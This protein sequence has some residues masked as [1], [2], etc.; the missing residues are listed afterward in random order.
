MRIAGEFNEN[1]FYNKII[2]SGKPGKE[3]LNLNS[4]IKRELPRFSCTIISELGCILMFRNSVS[5]FSS[6][7]LVNRKI[8]GKI[9]W[10]SVI[11]VLQASTVILKFGCLSLLERLYEYGFVIKGLAV[12][13]KFLEGDK[14]WMT[15][16]KNY[17][18]V[19]E[20]NTW[21][22]EFELSMK[23]HSGRKLSYWK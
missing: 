16:Y 6:L 22:S 4:N 20:Q 5:K 13:W 14:S 18:N 19:I 23:T 9:C 21:Y 11:V 17:K 12:F 2:F 10:D 15:R 1:R 3:I 7:L 8:V